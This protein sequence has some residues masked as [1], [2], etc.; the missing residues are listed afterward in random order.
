MFVLR[1]A[2]PSHVALARCDVL[3]LADA[4]AQA[5]RSFVAADRF[6]TL[7]SVAALLD[8]CAA[9]C[10]C[11]CALCAC[12][13]IPGRR[14]ERALTTLL[15]VAEGD[16]TCYFAAFQASQAAVFAASVPCRPLFILA[17]H[18][19]LQGSGMSPA[20]VC[21]ATTLWLQTT[22]ALIA[23][24]ILLHIWVKGG[25]GRSR[26]GSSGSTDSD[27]GGSVTS[28]C[29]APSRPAWQRRQVT[30]LRVLGEWVEEVPVHM[31]LFLSMMTWLALRVFFFLHPA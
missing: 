23:P 16:S 2:S 9:A 18:A 8:W 11:C 27:S 12:L 10:I 29:D 15:P 24:A 5:A 22:C 19:A 30:A 20:G 3:P 6:G 25:S 7:E 21:L 4:A 31:G 13:I 17:P 14:T 1:Q 28:G 26:G